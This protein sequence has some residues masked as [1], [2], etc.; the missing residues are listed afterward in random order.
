MARRIAF[1]RAVNVGG[2]TIPMAELRRSFERLGGTDVETFIA[3]GNVIFEHTSRSEPALCQ[4]IESALREEYGYEVATFVRGPAELRALV[5]HAAFPA[6]AVATAGALC[7]GFL[8]RAP[9]AETVQRLA[10][11]ATTIDALCVHGRELYWLCR[12]KQS[13]SKLTN[14]ALE[15]ALGQP[16]TLRSITTLR[17]LA[18]K[19]PS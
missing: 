16:T 12:V 9:D 7:V 19:Y 17:K 8:A 4:R 14:K 15:R 18:A 10:A 6:K 3:S 1:L 11:L 5:E 13:E 2:R